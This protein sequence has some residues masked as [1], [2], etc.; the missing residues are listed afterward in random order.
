MPDQVHFRSTLR[1]RS[2]AMLQRRLPAL[3]SLMKKI[4]LF[5]HRDSYLHSSGLFH[6]YRRGYPVDEHDQPLPW[7]NYNIIHLLQERLNDGLAVFEYGSGYST[8]FLAGK[9]ASV[10]SIEYDRAWFEQMRPRVPANVTLLHQ[11]FEYDGPYCRSILQD[12]TRYDLVI[13]DGRDRVRCAENAVSRLSERGVILFDDSDRK[14]Y[15]EGLAALRERG[16]RSLNFE[17]LKP[18]GFVRHHSTLFY[19]PEN[20]LGI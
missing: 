10:V 15:A 5:H 7:M 17:G 11:E 20:C 3:L 1:S 9:V 6:S 4:R 16:F 13:V 2:I 14:A 18:L 8:M 12:D 19:R